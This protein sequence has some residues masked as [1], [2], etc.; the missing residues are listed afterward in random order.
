[1]S[2]FI[3]RIIVVVPHELVRQR[4]LAQSF[5]ELAILC[6]LLNLTLHPDKV[7]DLPRTTQ[8]CKH[9]VE[10]EM[11]ASVCA[12]RA[13]K[14]GRQ[15]PQQIT[16]K[17]WFGYAFPTAV[18]STPIVNGPRNTRRV[19]I[20]RER[21]ITKSM[22]EGSDTE[23]KQENKL[24]VSATNK[25]LQI[26][27]AKRASDGEN[28]SPCPVEIRHRI[29]PLLDRR[30]KKCSAPCPCRPVTQRRRTGSR[31]GCRLLCSSSSTHWYLCRRKGQVWS[32]S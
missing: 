16:G 24:S 19:R 9:V 30:E 29:L 28:N 13:N 21:T 7:H 32:I 15:A 4:Y 22:T 26:P 6:L 25:S 1:M 2:H 11:R 17:D 10:G 14:E 31:T 5:A 8:V 20:E 23:S 18:I 12:F 27:P 3:S